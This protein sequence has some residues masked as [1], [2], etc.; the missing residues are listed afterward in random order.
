MQVDIREP[1]LRRPLQIGFARMLT[2]RTI[3][4]TDRRG[5]YLHFLLDDGQIWLVHLGMTGQLI[6]ETQEALPLLHD[7]VRIALNS[8]HHLRYND[9]R[10]FGLMEVGTPEEIAAVTHLGCEPLGKEFTSLYFLGK[11]QKTKRTIKDVLMDQR[12]F[13]GVG[14]I[15]ASE[16]LF[17]AGVRPGRGATTLDLIA[18]ERIVKAT[19]AVLREAIRHR[20]SSISD[21]RDGE[22][23]RGEFQQRFQVYDR[24]GE[25]CRVCRATIC[26]DT[27]GGRSS[28]FCPT[29]QT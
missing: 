27:Q 7:H 24:E 3:R 14:N 10:R 26:R 28:F 5:K 2:G 8:G 12:V 15:Y 23:K 4:A 16:L 25:P 17:R 13:A 21:Y 20:G 11:T 29:C 9:P 19:K 18:V 6:V 1:R 22:G